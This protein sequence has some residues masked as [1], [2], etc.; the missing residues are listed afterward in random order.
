M[1]SLIHLRC[2]DSARPRSGKRPSRI[3]STTLMGTLIFR[4]YSISGPHSSL[5]EFRVQRGQC[6][7]YIPSEIGHLAHLVLMPDKHVA[8]SN[9]SRKFTRSVTAP[10]STGLFS[11]RERSPLRSL[12][13][14]GP[15][16]CVQIFLA[17]NQIRVLPFELFSLQNM[18]V[19]SLRKC[20]NCC[21]F[22]LSTTGPP[23][24][25]IMQ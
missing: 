2:L 9:T 10:A 21:S 14:Q 18:T 13:R 12:L 3:L 17:Q 6:L 4:A 8:V 23:L 24:Q 20:T 5:Y 11:R 15:S 22:I 25:E 1:L 7:S 16:N 19:L